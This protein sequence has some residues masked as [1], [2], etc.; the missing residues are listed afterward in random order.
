MRLLLIGLLVLTELNIIAFARKTPET[1]W[2]VND[3]LQDIE[4]VKE[5]LALLSQEIK[6]IKESLA[7]L[8]QDVKENFA[9]MNKRILIIEGKT[10]FS[11]LTSNQA[12]VLADPNNPRGGYVRLAIGSVIPS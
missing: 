10:R 3:L 5:N 11:P 7:V 4:D 1:L 6:E 8:S 12:F 9:A 2:D